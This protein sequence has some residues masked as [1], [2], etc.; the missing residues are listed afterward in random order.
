M[1]KNVVYEKKLNTNERTH[2]KSPASNIS[3]IARII[4]DVSAD[5]L[6]EVIKK[7]QI[8]YPILNAHVKTKESEIWLLGNG[9]MEIPLKV[10]PRGSDNH[11]KEQ[12]L[13]EHKIPFSFKEGPLIRFIL[14]YSSEISDL[15]IFSQHIICDG[16]SLAYLARDIMVHLEDPFKGVK[17]LPSASKFDENIIPDDIKP[18][19][20]LRLFGWIIRKKWEKDE[21]IFDF[22]DFNELHTVFWKKYDYEAHLYELSKEH[23][24]AFVSACHKHLVTVNSALIAAFALAQNKLDI[25]SHRNLTDYASAVNLR[26]ELKKP[27]GE[28]FG[29]FAG[30]VSF[31]YEFKDEMN[32][33]DAAKAVY[34]EINPEDAKED[35]LISTLN[36]FKIPPSL[37]E[38]Q[39]FAAFGHLIPPDSPS[40]NKIQEFL[41][42]DK[43]MAIK[44]AQKKLSSKNRT[45]MTQI[46]TNLGKLDFPEQYGDLHLKNLILMPSCSPYTELVLGVVTQGGTLCITLNHMESTIKT[47]NVL[48]I[49]EIA[50]EIIMNAIKQ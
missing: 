3:I 24:K 17:K 13:K 34:D 12:I 8:R 31:T 22:Q 48:K 39:I 9:N 42:D 36:K 6:R 33:W 38:A 23:T 40:Y 4:G 16:L 46:M 18:N 37:I 14:L 43:N 7:M 1:E 2:A 21:V 28:Q 41:N 32:F 45:F 49:K 30:G 19:L 26:D 47:K 10:I 25:D 5:A 44:M 29:L 15:I 11:W 35:A 20:S 50:N 27:I